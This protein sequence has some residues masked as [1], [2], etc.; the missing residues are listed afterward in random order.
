MKNYD[1]GLMWA[2]YM[3]VMGQ[4]GVIQGT[5]NS[6]ML[7]GIFYTTTAK[8]SFGIPLWAY[9]SVIGLGIIGVLIFI[10]TI[11]ISG[12]Y[13][14]FNQQS[15]VNGIK[16]ELKQMHKE[17]LALRRLIKKALRRHYVEVGNRQ[18]LNAE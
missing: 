13:R 1:I 4:V 6:L 15:A 18:R 17:N 16:S 8:P 3:A 14:F 5:I 9:L 10:L 2:K 11:G 7:V 12:Y